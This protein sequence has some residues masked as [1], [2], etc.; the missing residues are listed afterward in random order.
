M[1]DWAFGSFHF[2]WELR[3]QV[4]SSIKKVWSYI[5]RVVIETCVSS[6][7]GWAFGEGAIGG[8]TCG[9]P[10]RANCKIYKTSKPKTKKN[11]YIV[12]TASS[13]SMSSETPN[14]QPKV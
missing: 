11:D 8:V 2:G 10:R 13:K 3:G 7:F 9:K 12:H 1:G 14:K 4:Y 5:M 6:L